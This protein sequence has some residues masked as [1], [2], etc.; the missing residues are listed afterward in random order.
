MN[1]ANSAKID[2]TFN[3]TIVE[4]KWSRLLYFSKNEITFNRTIVELKCNMD[5]G[6][7]A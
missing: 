7:D 6:I 5:G 2:F 3:R 1:A 4:L